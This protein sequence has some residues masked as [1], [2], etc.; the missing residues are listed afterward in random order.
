MVAEAVADGLHADATLQEPHCER[1]PQAVG[2]VLLKGK[3]AFMSQL[4]EDIA[5][6]RVLYSSSRIART[7]E[8][9]RMI[10]IWAPATQ[11]PAQ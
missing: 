3:P 10:R 2:G 5:H 8:Q 1:V 7:Q 9:L 11:V 6:R 4:I